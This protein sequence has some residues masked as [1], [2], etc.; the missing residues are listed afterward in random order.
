MIDVL[1]QNGQRATDLYAGLISQRD[2]YLQ[3]IDNQQDAAN[4]LVNSWISYS[5]FS[6]INVDSLDSFEEYRQ[7][8]I[9]ESKNDESIGKMLADGTLS[10]EDLEKAI[11]DFMATSTKFSKWYEKWI[12]D[13]QNNSK[14]KIETLKITFDS[15]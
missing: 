7:K 5:Q 10:D 2:K 6:K 13:T 15:A 4:S 12:K 8:M 9:E 11:D 3:Y 14:Q 1:E